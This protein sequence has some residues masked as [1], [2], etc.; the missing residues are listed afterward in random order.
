MT[1]ILVTYTMDYYKDDHNMN[2]NLNDENVLDEEKKKVK[3]KRKYYTS[4][5]QDMLIRNGITGEKYAIKK[6]TKFESELFKVMDTTGR[7]DE[8]GFLLNKKKNN[9]TTN[10]IYY[11]S[12]EEYQRFIGKKLPD[13]VI[14]NWRKRN[15]SLKDDTA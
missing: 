6:G 4:N 8:D 9:P 15:G 7:V 12:P 1:L 3:K 13:F 10:T 5:N 2:I 14:T 11:N